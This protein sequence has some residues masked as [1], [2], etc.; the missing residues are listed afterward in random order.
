MFDNQLCWPLAG[1]PKPIQPIQ[2]RDTF[3]SELPS[4]V[5]FTAFPPLIVIT[6]N[7]SI[8]LSGYTLSVLPHP[9]QVVDTMSTIAL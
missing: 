8:R 6:F 5:Y 7:P 3:K 2:M 4:F 1:S 9:Q